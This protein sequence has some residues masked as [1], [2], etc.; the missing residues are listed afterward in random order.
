MLEAAAGARPTLPAHLVEALDQAGGLAAG[1]KGGAE[2]VPDEEMRGMSLNDQNWYVCQKGF[3]QVQKFCDEIGLPHY[4]TTFIKNNYIVGYKLR[5]ITQFELMN[6]FELTDPDEIES[7]LSHSANLQKDPEVTE[8]V[9]KYGTPELLIWEC[10]QGLALIHELRPDLFEEKKEPD[11]IP[12]EDHQL[13]HAEKWAIPRA[14]FENFSS[15]EGTWC[16]S[17][18]CDGMVFLWPVD[19]PLQNPPPRNDLHYDPSTLDEGVTSPG[20]VRI[21]ESHVRECTDFCVDWEQMVTMSVGGD[22][23]VVFYDMVTNKKAGIIKN[24]KG[25]DGSEAFLSLDADAK[26]GKVVIGTAEGRIKIGDLERGKVVQVLKGHTDDVYDV[27]AD[28][29]AN[30]IVSIS[31]DWTG[32]MWDLRSGKRTRTMT[33][34]TAVINRLDCCFEQQM[35]VSF[36][37]DARSQ[38]IML[39]DLKDG[40]CVKTIDGHFGG[41]NDGVV[42]WT[43]S[44]CVT[45]GEDG[46]VK[47][48]DL[49]S[50]ECKRTFDCNHIQTLAVDVNWDKGLLMTA[51]WDYKVRVWDLQ[52]GKQCL[53]LTKPRRCMTQCAIQG[54]RKSM[55]C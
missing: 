21:C 18:G 50:G 41:T 14:D 15:T 22:C 49:A 34:H 48:W 24:D 45:G 8:F 46:L 28:W 33:G 44:E 37:A 25:L 27:K 31:W 51:S 5:T 7:I 9:G 32:G 12:T 53:D 38:T 1:D 16:A 52:T 13:T 26:L 10:T 29:D 6:K 23:R 35:M 43:N 54:G 55:F 3:A 39:W 47:V 40:R 17:S 42:N 11:A 2:D 19:R 20:V 4:Y 36:G 30:T